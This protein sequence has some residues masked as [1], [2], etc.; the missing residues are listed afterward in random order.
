[1]IL[2]FQLR[3][4]DQSGLKQ[5]PHFHE[6]RGKRMHDSILVYRK[7]GG[8]GEKNSRCYLATWNRCSHSL[9]EE[10]SRL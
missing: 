10:R 7:P 2:V 8:L 9:V 6:L 5:W 4:R 1:M 3:M